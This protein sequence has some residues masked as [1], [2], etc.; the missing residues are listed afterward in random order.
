VGEGDYSGAQQDEATEQQTGPTGAQLV[1]K[2]APEEHDDDGGHGICRVEIPDSA[3]VQ[4][5][6]LDE[7]GSEG[8]DAVIGEIASQDYQADEH[9][10]GEAIGAL[11]W[12]EES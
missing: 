6:R 2:H 12:M 4:M 10:D 9:Q 5:Q 3:A 1:V 11:G 7:C 8:A